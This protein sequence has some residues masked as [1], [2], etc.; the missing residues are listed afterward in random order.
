M[1][2]YSQDVNGKSEYMAI[3][4]PSSLGKGIYLMQFSGQGW[5]TTGKFVIP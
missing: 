2:V 3:T 1:P 5:K 4:L